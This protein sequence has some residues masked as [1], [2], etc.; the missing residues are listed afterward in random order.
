MGLEGADV[1]GTPLKLLSLG[2]PPSF[3]ERLGDFVVI[4]GVLPLYS[5]LRS[6]PLCDPPLVTWKN[7]GFLSAH[8]PSDGGRDRRM[9]TRPPP[10]SSAA[11]VP[12]GLST[13]TCCRDGLIRSDF[14][15]FSFWTLPVTS[16]SFFS[17]SQRLA[18]LPSMA[19][20]FSVHFLTELADH[21]TCFE[22]Q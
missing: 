6:A 14:E 12:P 5:S 7:I 17:S 20:L 19:L 4:S 9:N 2:V 15:S 11:R 16:S 18:L 13:G 21:Q 8:P 3:L 22:K 10:A 1:F